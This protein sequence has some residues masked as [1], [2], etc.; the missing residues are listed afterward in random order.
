MNTTTSF[1]FTA[2]E[3]YGHAN[4]IKY[5]DR[6]FVSVEEMDSEI[7][8]RHNE[9]VG[10]QDVVI[11]AGEFT[12]AKKPIAENYIK[13]LNGTHIFLK[14]SHDYWL[15]KSAAMIWER[16]IQGFYVVVCHFAMRLWPWRTARPGRQEVWYGFWDIP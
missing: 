16:E 1:F 4:I 3:H 14:G 15:K 12:L 11:H 13:R 10:S 8:K 7:I 5:C 6:P 2:D 9:L